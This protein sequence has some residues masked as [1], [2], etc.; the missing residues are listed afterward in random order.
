M[1]KRSQIRKQ[2]RTTIFYS[3]VLASGAANALTFN[4]AVDCSPQDVPEFCYGASGPNTPDYCRFPDG[5]VFRQSYEKRAAAANCFDR[6]TA[7]FRLVNGQLL[8]LANG[9]NNISFIQP[10]G[11]PVMPVSGYMSMLSDEA[12]QAG[13]TWYDDPPYLNSDSHI[14]CAGPGTGLCWMKGHNPAHGD[15]VPQ[16][17]DNWD[18]CE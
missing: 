2:I 16:S 11:I 1:T 17:T 3:I 12:I 18:E 4:T 7:G 8:W 15:P 5:S 10:R 14:F 9:G 6:A 13:C